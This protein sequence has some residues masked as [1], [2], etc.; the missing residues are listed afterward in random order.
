MYFYN[1]ILTFA[2]VRFYIIGGDHSIAFGSVAAALKANPD[3]GVIWVDAHADLNTP[4]TSPSGNMHGMPLGILM[5]LYDP[6]TIPGFEW[7]SDIPKL[8]P[9]QLSY[10]GLR[11]VDQGEANFVRELGIQTFTMH[12]IDLYG[13]GGVV[14]QVLD[15]Q[16]DRPLH[17]SYDIDAVDP[18]E[19]PSTGT[20]VRGGLTFREA[21]YVAE[22]VSDTGNLKSMDIVEVNP[23]LEPG[24]G[25]NMTADMGLQLT[26]SAM[27]TRIL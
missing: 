1:K 9:E 8:K 15:H 20:V 10:I 19:A 3:V 4:L 18:I 5:H 25:A 24:E 6:S 27:G 11:D 13:I 14:A 2:H 17:M 16:G 26:L 21:H 23:Q 22:A 12:H 7:M